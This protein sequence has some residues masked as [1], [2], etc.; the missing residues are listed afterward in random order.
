MSFFIFA[1]CPG[2]RNTSFL[3]G[4]SLFSFKIRT[5]ND[6][7]MSFLHTSSKGTPNFTLQQQNLIDFQS[8]NTL[9]SERRAYTLHTSHI[10]Q[11]F[12]PKSCFPTNGTI[13]FNLGLPG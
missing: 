5:S 3:T 13:H 12:R 2:A 7:G 11:G 1:W 10:H 8:M 6:P 9:A 4:A